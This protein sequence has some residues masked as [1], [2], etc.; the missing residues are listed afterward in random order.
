MQ[1]YV[2]KQSSPQN[3]A[4]PLFFV[5][6][7][8]ME[9]RTVLAAAEGE[10]RHSEEVHRSN[11]FAMIAQKWSLLLDKKLN[12]RWRSPAAHRPGV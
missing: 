12:F 8:A 7:H 2:E 5:A 1:K 4:F 3:S 6:V 9:F 10:P 11:D